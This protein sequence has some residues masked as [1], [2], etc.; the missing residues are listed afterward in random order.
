MTSAQRPVAQTAL[1]AGFFNAFLDMLVHQGFVPAEDV[2]WVALTR[3]QL[4]CI[5]EEEKCCPVRK[6]AFKIH[7]DV[8]F[9]ESPWSSEVTTS[10]QLRSHVAW[11]LTK[12]TRHLFLF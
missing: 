9:R 10:A 4:S 8:T 12:R 6:T 11:N 2:A 7:G 5:P 1:P 3:E